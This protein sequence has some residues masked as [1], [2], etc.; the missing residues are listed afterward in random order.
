MKKV[1]LNLIEIRFNKFNDLKKTVLFFGAFLSMYLVFK[2]MA[3]MKIVGFRRQTANNPSNPACM[4]F[5]QR[6]A[7]RRCDAQ[8]SL[9]ISSF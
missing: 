2:T 7:T 8:R 6:P 9:R 1:D 5:A 3:H 4:R